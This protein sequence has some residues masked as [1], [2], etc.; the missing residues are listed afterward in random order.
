M[1]LCP[2]FSMDRKDPTPGGIAPDKLHEAVVDGFVRVREIVVHRGPVGVHGGSVRQHGSPCMHAGRAWLW[3][4]PPPPRLD[5]RP[6]PSHWPRGLA[7]GAA[8]RSGL[9]NGLAHVGPLA[10][11]AGLVYLDRAGEQ[12]TSLPDLVPRSPSQAGIVDC[13][14]MG[15]MGIEQD[16]AGTAW[17]AQ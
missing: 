7:D 13:E 3:T 4:A 5:W 10:A 16:H 14:P 17:S 1:P 2:R 15:H 9:R 12:T 6:G 11:H 8:S